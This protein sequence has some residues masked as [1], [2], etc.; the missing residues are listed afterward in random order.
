[1]DEHCNAC[2]APHMEKRLARV[3]DPQ[4][5]EHFA[6]VR[7]P[8]CGLGHTTPEP[9][10]LSGY[11]G[12][13]YY[14]GRHSFT[15]RYCTARRGRILRDSTRRP[16]KILDIGCGDGSFLSAVEREGWSVTGTEMG[17][18]AELSKKIGIDVRDSLE[19]ARDRGPFDAITMWHT[20]EHFRDPKAIVAAVR[21]LLAEDGV[22]IVAVPDAAGL[23]A[24]VFKEKWFHLDVPRHLYHFTRGS[25]DG[26]LQ[27]SGFV[28]ER[29]RHQELEL[30][31]FGWL[32]SALNTVFPMPN[33][34]FQSLTGKPRTTGTT[35]LALSYAL[36]TVLGPAAIAATALGTVT[37][38]GG[39]LI[40][41]ARSADIRGAQSRISGSPR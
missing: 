20:L 34:L 14:G 23:Q 24:T 29:W 12:P 17:G 30:D 38:R 36:G 40:A 25:L 8:A 13:A 11:Y 7:C 5:T 22:F 15:A 4:S 16:G 21:G 35:Q 27:S 1:M 2:G 33:V 26:L 32:Q 9:E 3:R 37:G 6:I 39:T 31:L 28:V 41:I 18:A 10:D 19:E